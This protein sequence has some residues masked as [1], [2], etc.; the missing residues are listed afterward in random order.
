MQ[1]LFVLP[2]FFSTL[3][4]GLQKVHV[5]VSTFGDHYHSHHS[6]LLETQDEETVSPLVTEVLQELVDELPGGTRYTVFAP[7][8]AAF[9]RLGFKV[10]AFLFSPF[11]RRVLKDV[12]R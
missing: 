6:G 4:S 8:N 7:V 12:L 11:G 1:T 9:A 5:N 3:T 2:Q 10:N